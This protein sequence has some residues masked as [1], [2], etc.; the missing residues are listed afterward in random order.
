MQHNSRAD[1]GYRMVI[2]NN[3]SLL[4]HPV[5]FYDL[6]PSYW[7]SSSLGE[8]DYIVCKS[9]VSTKQSNYTETSNYVLPNPGRQ[10]I[11]GLDHRG[12]QEPLGLTSKTPSLQIQEE[13]TPCKRLGGVTSRSWLGIER[14]PYCC[15]E[16]RSL[17]GISLWM[18]MRSH[19]MVGVKQ[20]NHMRLWPSVHSLPKLNKKLCYLNIPCFLSYLL[21]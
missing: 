10:W 17:V 12:I 8:A 21:F 9:V 16:S 4:M 13:P 14:C 18:L 19:S 20:E 11:R 1:S 7:K 5:I 2:L 15:E 6:N 3:C